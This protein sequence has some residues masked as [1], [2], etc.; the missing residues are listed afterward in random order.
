MPASKRD[1]TC[2]VE[3]FFF[4]FLSFLL[5]SLLLTYH[6]QRERIIQVREHVLQNPRL[7]NRL[8]LGRLSV[9]PTIIIGARVTN[10]GTTWTTICSRGA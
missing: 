2:G 7:F 6:R 9:D 1:C 3:I 5:L 8:P 4:H 10:I